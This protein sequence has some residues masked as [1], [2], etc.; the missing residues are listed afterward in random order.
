MALAP[1]T[2]IGD[3]TWLFG[4]PKRH[5]TR[6]IRRMPSRHHWR[7][8]SMGASDRSWFAFKL[9]HF[10]NLKGGP[11]EGLPRTYCHRWERNCGLGVASA[12]RMAFPS[13]LIGRHID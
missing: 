4:G 7:P 9:A 10:Q 12:A 2:G 5:A 13:L 1:Q 6:L 3:P 11:K 8:V